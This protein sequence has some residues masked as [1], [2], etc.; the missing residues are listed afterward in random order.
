MKCPKCGNTKEISSTLM[1]F[2]NVGKPCKDENYAT[3]HKCKHKAYAWE[4]G[5]PNVPPIKGTEGWSDK[6]I[7]QWYKDMAEGKIE[8]GIKKGVGFINMRG[9]QLKEYDTE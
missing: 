2:M 5:A 1:G 4:F 3:C 7:K 6:K 8:I 9:I